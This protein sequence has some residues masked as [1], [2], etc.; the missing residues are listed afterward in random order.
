MIVALVG[1]FSILSLLACLLAS[2]PP[3]HRCVLKMDHHCPWVA[4]CIGFSNYK[5]FINMLFY[6]SLDTLLIVFTSWPLF[7]AVLN[8]DQADYIMAYYL[9][10]SFLLSVTMCFVVTCFFIFHLWLISN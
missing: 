4:N 5:F 6:T 10:T 7:Q 1:L 9:I 8:S 3:N 2:L